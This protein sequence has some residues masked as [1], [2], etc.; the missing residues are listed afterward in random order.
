MGVAV[1]AVVALAMCGLLPALETGTASTAPPANEQG[2][3]TFKPGQN[4]AYVFDTGVLRGTLR[5]G[6][7]S[8]GLLPVAHVPSATRLD[9]SVGIL[10]FY[11]VFTTNRRHW[12]AGWDWPSTAALQPD[13]AVRITWPAL[14]D[15]PF[16]LSGVYR[17]HDAQTLDVTTTVKAVQELDHFEVFLAS[18]F[19]ESF[20]SPYVY[21]QA[22]P[23]AGGKPGFMLARKSYGDWQMFPRDDAAVAL[24]RDGRWTKEPHPVN[25]AV[26]PR[27]AAPVCV[28]R[29]GNSD[30]TMI[31]MAPPDDCFA[32][33]TPYEGEGHYSLYLSLFGR[34]IQAGET[35]VAHTRLV[36][37]TGSSDAQVLARYERYVGELE[38]SQP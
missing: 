23:Q 21:V 12:T 38:S 14:K 16:E 29:G 36:V 33:A 10:S 15:R 34:D 3:L 13:G 27:L 8:L 5:Q 31:L 24:V 19:Q 9:R 32:I 35:A 7:K 11:R 2:S 25:W 26:M 37:A 30:L 22:N 20:S 28:R 1:A 17:W 4:G 18:Y 6:G